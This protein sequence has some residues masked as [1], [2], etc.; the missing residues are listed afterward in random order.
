MQQFLILSDLK[1]YIGAYLS[2]QNS[3]SLLIDKKQ[4]GKFKRLWSSDDFLIFLHY[5]HCYLFPTIRKN[6]TENLFKD[7]G[8]K[9]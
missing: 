1:S 5:N 9:F 3:P 7:E 2:L 8:I 6:K 4:D